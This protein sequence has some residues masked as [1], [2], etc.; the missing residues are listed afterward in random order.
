MYNKAV[1]IIDWGADRSRSALQMGILLYGIEGAS[2]RVFP[3]G[4]TKSHSPG[5][6]PPKVPRSSCNH[7]WGLGFRCVNWRGTQQQVYLCT[8]H[9][10]PSLNNFIKPPRQD[11]V[12]PPSPLKG[13]CPLPVKPVWSL[14]SSTLKEPEE[15]RIRL[16]T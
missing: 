5:L 12:L 3:D 14:C 2:S 15:H 11:V 16:W 1:K 9:G 4:D 7:I 6:D 8:G 10:F 13:P